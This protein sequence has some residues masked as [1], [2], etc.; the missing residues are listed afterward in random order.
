MNQ[1]KSKR[2]MN[3]SYDNDSRKSDDAESDD[4][5]NANLEETFI[6]DVSVFEVSPRGNFIVSFVSQE[7]LCLKLLPNAL[8]ENDNVYK[9]CFNSGYMMDE[10]PDYHHDD[11]MYDNT[12]HEVTKDGKATA[13]SINNDQAKNEPEIGG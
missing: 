12:R 3:N 10:H 1:M 5:S 9:S 8:Y 4:A 2:N 7:H 11:E 13:F 6:D